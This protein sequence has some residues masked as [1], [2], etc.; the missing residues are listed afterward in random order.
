M[1]VTTDSC[2]FGAWAAM[3]IQNAK[4]EIKNVLD[5][6][7]GTGL[8]SL[9]IAQKKN[10]QIDAVEIETNAAEQ[11]QENVHGT[12]WKDR[13]QVF[14]ENILSFHPDKKYDCIICNPPFYEKE[15][16]SE[17]QTKNVAHHSSQ[18]TISQILPVIQQN[19]NAGGIFFLMLPYK[20][21]E[22]IEKLIS[23]N[24][25]HVAKSVILK[26]SA[27]HWPFRVIVMGTKGV[28]ETAKPIEISVCNEPQHYTKEFSD[29]LKDYYLYL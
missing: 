28:I 18:L 27:R 12:P 8:L 1:K 7:T 25:L 23:K 4:C 13:I 5:I 9:M 20:R 22:Q 17:D 15:L 26:Q 29:L 11:A 10:V 3:E 14:N 24:E 2:F 16:A 21:K 6:G 19:L